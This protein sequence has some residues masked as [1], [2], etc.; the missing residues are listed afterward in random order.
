M[1][2]AVSLGSLTKVWAGKGEARPGVRHTRLEAG[3]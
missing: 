3:W 2:D 1:T